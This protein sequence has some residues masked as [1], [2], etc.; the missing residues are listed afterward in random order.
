MNRFRIG[1]MLALLPMVAA[2][3]QPQEGRIW[4]LYDTKS[5][6]RSTS[7]QLNMERDETSNGREI[8]QADGCLEMRPIISVVDNT[9]VW[10][11]YEVEDWKLNSVG[12]RTAKRLYVTDPP[13]QPYPNSTSEARPEEMPPAVRLKTGLDTEELSL[14]TYPVKVRWQI[15]TGDVKSWI[16][17]PQDVRVALSGEWIA[18]E[19]ALQRRKIY[20]CESALSKLLALPS[21]EF[22]VLIRLEA[23]NWKSSSR[24]VKSSDY[25]LRE[26]VSR[27]LIEA[28]L[29]T[30][31]RKSTPTPGSG[32]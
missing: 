16:N 15:V 17:D 21:G 31:T 13:G 1:L 26:K 12:V 20:L 22:I 3:T 14:S 2:C 29:R 8:F 25:F 9:E 6:Y 30:A 32:S 24:V 7:L 28:T 19:P 5:E 11:V 27:Q 10:R 23:E 18:D 4:T